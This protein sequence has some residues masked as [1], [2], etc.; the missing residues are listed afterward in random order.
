MLTK[1]A[2]RKLSLGEWGKLH[3]ELDSYASQGYEHQEALMSEVLTICP[4]LEELFEIRDQGK[5]ESNAT[6]LEKAV[7]DIEFWTM[8]FLLGRRLKAW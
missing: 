2:L 4:F 5:R 1:K 7:N 3:E 8:L 6:M